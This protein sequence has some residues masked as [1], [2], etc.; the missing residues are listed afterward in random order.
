MLLREFAKRREVSLVGKFGQGLAPIVSNI[1]RFF[2]NVANQSWQVWRE[3]VSA[4]LAKF[5]EQIAGPVRSVN[6]QAVAEHSVGRVFA[7]GLQHG[8]A[9]MLQ[10]VFDCGAIIVIQHETLGAHGWTLHLLC[11]AA[12]YEE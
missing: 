5:V 3:I 12:R 6:F 7:K 11:G 9:G 1:R 2:A 8:L 4:A 10:M